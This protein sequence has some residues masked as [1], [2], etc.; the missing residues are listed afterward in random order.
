MRSPWILSLALTAC[1]SPQHRAP[2]DLRGEVIRSAT[3]LIGQRQ[4][5]LSGRLL[6]SDCLAL[7]R[8]AFG[9]HGISLGATTALGLYRKLQREGH[10]FAGTPQRGDLV[11]IRDLGRE[12]AL[13]VGL[14]G[15]VERDGTVTVYQRMSRGV[16]AYRMNP[17][18]PHDGFGSGH[19]PWNDS[20]AAG[21]GDTAPAGALFEAYASILP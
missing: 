3:D 1:A 6:P 7:P 14:V 9:E 10:V 13:H 19:R 11:F 16:E 21:N 2:V 18:H 8:A 4:I 5:S 15:R 20:I 17:S 12:N